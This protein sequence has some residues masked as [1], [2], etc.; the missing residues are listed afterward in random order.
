MIGA[1][2]PPRS[3]RRV[4]RAFCTTLA[5]ALLA[6]ALTASGAAAVTLQSIGSF[7][8]PIYVTSDPGDGG[9]LFVVERSGIVKKVDDGAV[10]VFANLTAQVGCGGGCGGERGLI[11]IALA[12]DFDSSGR[13]FVDYASELDGAIHVAELRASGGTAVGASPRELLT[14]EHPE[15]NNHY[16]GQLQ[17]GPEADLFVGTGDGGG[18][19]DEFHNAQNLGSLLGKILRLDP[20]P[21][22]VLPYTVPATNPFAKTAAAPFSTIWSYG[23]RNPFRFSFDSGGSGLWIGDV[24]QDTREEID[25]AAAPS[26]GGGANY[27]WNCFEAG[28]SGPGTDE[29]CSGSEASD[30]TPPVFEYPHEDP[31]DGGAHGCAVIGGYVVRDPALAGLYGRY[32]YGDLCDSE[33]RSFNPDSPASS[34]RAFG[35][36]VD[37]LNSFGEDACHRLYAVSGSGTVWRLVGPEA[38]ACP[39]ETPLRSAFAGIRAFSRHVLR[40]NRALITVWVSPCTGRQGERV[41]LF[42]GKRNLGSRRLSRACTARFRPRIHRRSTFRAQVAAGDGYTEATSRKLT[43]KPGKKRHHRHRAAAQ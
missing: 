32:L 15:A 13:L 26:L 1:S 37:D 2:N 43:I 3:L 31:G 27:G 6:L 4:I 33:L 5:A 29:G 7:D 35:L 16:A 22:G 17:F 12:P 34:D 38:S 23:L 30:F 14:I 18:G 9:R 36:S 41:R 20:D 21:S 28:E 40:G 11:S 8:E 24:G 10:S 39:A 25:F 42:L 19:N